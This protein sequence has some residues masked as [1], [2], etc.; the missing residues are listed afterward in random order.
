MK[1]KY[2]KSIP[3]KQ[4]K[5]GQVLTKRPFHWQSYILDNRWIFLIMA[6]TFLVFANALKNQFLNWDDNEYIFENPYIRDFSINGVIT[7][8]SV[9]VS[10]H[11][12]PLTLL[13]YTID[14]KLWGLN[15]M[16]FVL[17]NIVLH[18]F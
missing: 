8:F 13:S 16:G 12:H 9:F 3:K 15:P 6:F 4:N 17:G 5:Q 14:F 10:S 11:Y 1:K 18:I 7:L 2:H